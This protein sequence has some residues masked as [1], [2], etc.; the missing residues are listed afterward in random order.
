MAEIKTK[1]T[2]APVAKFIAAIKDARVR[3]DC[4][5]IVK[6][7][8][9]A[10]KAKGRMW[11][12]AIVGFGTRTIVYAGGREAEWMVMGFSPRKTELVL[13]GL[14]LSGPNEALLEKLGKHSRGKGCLYIKRLEDIHLPTLK[15]LVTASAK[16]AKG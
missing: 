6:L 10:T 1:L 8:E 16:R 5:A 2:G 14:G 12:S 7:M 9:G 4:K 15:K 11:G 3:D 13:Y